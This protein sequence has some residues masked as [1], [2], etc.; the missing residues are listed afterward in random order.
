MLVVTTG[1]A[2]LAFKAPLGGDGPP[3]PIPGLFRF[4]H[5]QLPVQ[6][7]LPARI[8]R[9][10]AKDLAPPEEQPGGEGGDPAP[11]AGVL[12]QLKAASEWKDPRYRPLDLRLARR[13]AEV[14][15]PDATTEEHLWAARR[16]AEATKAAGP[17][18]LAADAESK[19][20]EWRGL[21]AEEGRLPAGPPEP[22]G[23]RRGAGEDRVVLMELFTGAECS[24]CAP[25]DRAFDILAGSLPHAELIAIQYH[26]HIPAPDPLANPDAEARAEYYGARGTPSTY[27]NGR[28]LA[29]GGV[30]PPGQDRKKYN[31]YR[32]VVESLLRGPKG[33]SIALK[34]MREGDE[35][36]I[37]A[38]A[39]VPQAAAGGPTPA[40]HRPGR[41]G[42]PLCR[43]ERGEG[44]SSGRPRPPRRARRLSPRR[45]PGAGRMHNPAR[46]GPL[47]PGGLPGRIPRFARLPRRLP[48]SPPPHRVPEAL[49]H[50]VRP[51]RRHQG[52]PARRRCPHR[53][54]AGRSGPLRSPRPGCTRRPKA[55]SSST[56]ANAFGL[57]PTARE[58]LASDGGRTSRC[59]RGRPHS[60]CWTARPS[61]SGR[62][63]P[64]QRSPG[65]GSRMRL[66]PEHIPVREQHPILGDFISSSASDSW[67]TSRRVMSEGREIL[68]SGW[69]R[70]PTEE[71]VRLRISIEGRIEELVAKAVAAI[72]ARRENPGGAD[73]PGKT[74]C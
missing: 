36:R 18:E 74:S 66:R 52:G 31:Q 62:A 15:P 2:D 9:T 25:A 46:P 29:G 72:Q 32:R 4:R 34:A 63:P 20:A 21:L 44:P 42:S 16:L 8:E 6:A 33:A 13:A 17:P 3:G 53:R 54:R 35:V 49:G 1:Y 19:V 43:R 10:E 64:T 40:P 22:K 28:P 23:I 47:K 67:L 59:H 30:P 11:A 70:R 58:P 12:G 39:E 68:L 27:F 65:S 7:T 5:P 45:W 48:A 61:P 55:G 69:G 51:G 73:S 38:T 60:G 71:Q 14:V 57:F 24:P 50:C 56:K 26:L 41:G 37:Q